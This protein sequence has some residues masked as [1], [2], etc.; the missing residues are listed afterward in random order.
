MVSK[1]NRTFLLKLMTA[2]VLSSSLVC[3]AYSEGEADFSYFSLVEAKPIKLINPI[4]LDTSQGNTV[5][6]KANT[7]IP[8][9]LRSFSESDY[10][11]SSIDD[12]PK[13]VEKP[14]QPLDKTAVQKPNPPPESALDESTDLFTPQPTATDFF[15][16]LDETQDSSGVEVPSGVPDIITAKERRI[17]HTSV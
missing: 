3:P 12:E 14:T 9:N 15:S 13:T 11:S 5:L 2:L 16:P 6:P 4:Y 7:S 10:F 8:F 17:F 1:R